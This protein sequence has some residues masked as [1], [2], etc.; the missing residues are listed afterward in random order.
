MWIDKV[1]VYILLKNNY[2]YLQCKQYALTCNQSCRHF[3]STKMHQIT[4][5]TKN[6]LIIH[7]A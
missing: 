1:I 4:K 6:R 2:K 5:M 3:I 7:L